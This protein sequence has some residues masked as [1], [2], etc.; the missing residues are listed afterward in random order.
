MDES[1]LI[2][3]L[4]STAAWDDEFHAAKNLQTVYGVKGARALEIAKKA[5]NYISSINDPRP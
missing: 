1:N 3:Y 4:E 2:E 5:N